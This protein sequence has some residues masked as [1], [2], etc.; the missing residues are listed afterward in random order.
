[1][2]QRRDAQPQR[3]QL[4]ELFALT[5][6]HSSKPVLADNNVL[7]AVGG[8]RAVMLDPF[9]FR[10]LSMK[11]PSFPRR[12]WKDLETHRFGAVVLGCD[13]RTPDGEYWLREMD[14]GP[15]FAER[16][17]QSYNL[18]TEKYGCYIFTPRD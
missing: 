18:S 9:M 2:Y 3:R 12:L 7:L 6:G 4:Q 14:F 1:V 5:H 10:V 8:V 16:L 15:G 11:N 17:L 13:P